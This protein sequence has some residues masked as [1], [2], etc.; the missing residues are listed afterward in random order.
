MYSKKTSVPGSIFGHIYKVDE[1]DSKKTSVPGS[2]FC[3]HV[4]LMH[5][6]GDLAAHA[7]FVNIKQAGQ[8]QWNN[9]VDKIF[10]LRGGGAGGNKSNTRNLSPLPSIGFSIAY[11]AT[12]LPFCFFVF[13]NH[14]FIFLS[15]V[16]DTEFHDQGLPW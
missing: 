13:L 11:G 12:R 15:S 14:E 1:V 4:H 6:D 5:A 7:E 10:A 9:G 3:E 8:G 2:L 16:F